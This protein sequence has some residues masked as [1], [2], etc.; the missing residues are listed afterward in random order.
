MAQ[1]SSSAPTRML[2]L[3][4]GEDSFRIRLRA[5][6]LISALLAGAAP[7]RGDLAS[8]ELTP[9]STAF[10]LVRI[11]ARSADPDEI[12][13]AGQSQGLFAAPD[14]RR[15]V[16][17]EHAEALS[18]TDV[19]GVFPPDAALVLVAPEP[20]RSARARGRK[21]AGKAPAAEVALLD[22]VENAAGTIER[23]DRLL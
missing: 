23:Y 22:A 20:M 1:A 13:M 14:E 9:T 12:V 7:T 2:Y 4:H 3:L 11:D 8:R 10:G 5:G 17:V 19:I 15:V 21:P 6:E 18:S 16:L